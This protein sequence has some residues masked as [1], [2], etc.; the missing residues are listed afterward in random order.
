MKYTLLCIY[1][2]VDG[3]FMIVWNKSWKNESKNNLKF[4]EIE[5]RNKGCQASW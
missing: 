5:K 2:N 1:F 3:V 4:S